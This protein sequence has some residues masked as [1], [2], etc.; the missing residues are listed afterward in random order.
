[1]FG[2]LQRILRNENIDLALFF[3]SDANIAYFAGVKPDTACLAI[4]ASG[5]PL[6]FVPGFEAPRMAKTSEIEVVQVG[7]D[8]LKTA[9]S[10]FPAGKIGIIPSSISYDLALNVR[11]EWSA[12]LVSIED[13]CRA[14][15]LVK[16]KE[17]IARITKE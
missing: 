6:L 9:C 16:T 1:M 4:P 13:S 14:L 10:A 11:S 3:N 5:K 15:R 7:R 17:E 12:E 8:F 2:R